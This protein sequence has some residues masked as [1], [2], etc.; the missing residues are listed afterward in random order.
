M[1]VEEY[2]SVFLNQTWVDSQGW[3][4]IKFYVIPKFKRKNC[5]KW[6]FCQGEENTT[7][8]DYIILGKHPERCI[9]DQFPFPPPLFSRCNACGLLQRCRS[10]YVRGG[11]CLSRAR[12]G[13]HMKS[14][15]WVAGSTF[16]CRGNK[17]FRWQSSLTGVL[18]SDFCPSTQPPLCFAPSLA[19]PST[20]TA[21]VYPKSCCVWGRAL[22]IAPTTARTCFTST[23]PGRETTSCY[24]SSGPGLLLCSHQAHAETRRLQGP[25]RPSRT[26]SIKLRLNTGK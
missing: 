15:W 23:A 21:W 1:N 19:S 9:Q 24:S 10:W 8:C 2:P 5:F 3:I 18:P 20:V 6:R 22:L 26:V 12:Q 7:N 14:G 4:K 17:Y 11:H 13:S 25:F 16:V